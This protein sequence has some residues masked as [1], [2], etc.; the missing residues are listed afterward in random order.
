VLRWACTGAGQVVSGCRAYLPRGKDIP[1][2]SQEEEV[3][4][5]KAGKT[6]STRL[7]SPSGSILRSTCSLP[8]LDP[9]SLKP[10]H[11]YRVR[12]LLGA[13]ACQRLPG[14]TSLLP[15]RP[16][17]MP[18][19]AA[20]LGQPRKGGAAPCREGGWAPAAHPPLASP[21]HSK[22][23]PLSHA[24]QDGAAARKR[25]VMPRSHMLRPLVV[26]SPA[27]AATKRHTWRR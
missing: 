8:L 10:V 25:G 3:A 26:P 23:A 27:P 2:M 16:Q 11:I 9:S 4:W 7:Q 17:V 5:D 22:T 21:R 1:G 18:S 14:P 20:A 24:A 15:L 13:A 6:A 12:P 19:H